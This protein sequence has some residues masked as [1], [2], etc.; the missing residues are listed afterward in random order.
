MTPIENEPPHFAAFMDWP[1]QLKPDAKP[2]KPAKSIKRAVDPVLITTSVPVVATPVVTN[3]V[4]LVQWR[5][6]QLA[7]GVCRWLFR[8]LWRYFGIVI[9]EVLVRLGVW[10]AFALLG[11]MGILAVLAY[12]GVKDID[13]VRPPEPKPPTTSDSSNGHWKTI[14][15]PEPKSSDLN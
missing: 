13:D 14:V 5:W 7:R 2:Q 4:P 3:P 11:A 8:P 15:T 6:A 1:E 10:V 9:Y 12:I